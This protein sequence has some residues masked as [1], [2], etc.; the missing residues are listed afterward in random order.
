MQIKLLP[1]TSLRVHDNA[2]FAALD[3]PAS[4]RADRDAV[5][6]C[7]YA[8]ATH[9][10]NPDDPSSKGHA[11]R[12]KG[13]RNKNPGSVVERDAIKKAVEVSSWQCAALCC[14]LLGCWHATVVGGR[15]WCVC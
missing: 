10:N 3:L 9:F 1:G 8:A 13:H 12:T 4:E 14:G 7:I 11:N 15:V 2:V 5:V 6:R